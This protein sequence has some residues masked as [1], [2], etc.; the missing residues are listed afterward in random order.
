MES[1]SRCFS[2]TLLPLSETE[3][4]ERVQKCDKMIEEIS[5]KV[6]QYKKLMR[7]SLIEVL[8]DMRGCE[9]IGLCSK[10]DAGKIKDPFKK[11]YEKQGFERLHDRIDTIF[12]RYQ[13]KWKQ[14]T[15]WF[16]LSKECLW[17][18][19]VG[20]S[21]YDTF[22]AGPVL[23]LEEILKFMEEYTPL[24]YEESQVNILN[25]IIQSYFP[26]LGIEIIQSKS[27]AFEWI[28]W[29][30]NYI[31]RR[32]TKHKSHLPLLSPTQKIS[33]WLEG[34]REGNR[35]DSHY[36][37]S[38]LYGYPLS[39]LEHYLDNRKNKDKI[40]YLVYQYE[41]GKINRD[42]GFVVKNYTAEDVQE[43]LQR[44]RAFYEHQEVKKLVTKLGYDPQKES[45]GFIFRTRTEWMFWD[46]ISHAIR[47]K[48]HALIRFI[49]RENHK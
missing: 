36:A 43:T 11:R 41:N 24:T 33:E 12:L 23:S 38:I 9:E 32:L 28:V 25:T 18:P 37:K 5:E 42:S 22:Q 46:Y 3:M 4:N 16:R 29:N 45:F 31:N 27:K 39:T 20:Y 34:I 30:P 48:I 8:F 15:Q 13:W 17:E 6:P 7:S 35:K 10:R 26:N 40:S 49:Y 19:C 1:L 2:E 21:P 47:S 44:I 14:E